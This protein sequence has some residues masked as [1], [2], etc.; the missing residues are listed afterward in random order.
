MNLGDLNVAFVTGVVLTLIN[1]FGWIYKYFMKAYKLKRS[2]EVFHETVEQHGKDIGLATQSIK[3]LAGMK[4]ELY[5]I[6]K[7]I[8]RHNIVSSC[9]Q[10]IEKGS[11]EQYQL[12]SLEDMYNVYTTILNGNSYASTMMHR[13]RK[14]PIKSED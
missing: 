13:A 1:I 11:I 3:E 7:M 2:D 4:E 5:E 10:A 12:Q 8:L 6:N 14:L 9:Y